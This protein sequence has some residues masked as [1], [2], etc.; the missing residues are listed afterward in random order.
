MFLTDHSYSVIAKLE[1]PTITKKSTKE[2]NKVIVNIPKPLLER[3]DMICE[4]KYYTRVE[5]IK[6]ALHEFIINNMPEDRLL[7][8]VQK[9]VEEQTRST[10]HKL[11]QEF[12][13]V[14]VPKQKTLQQQKPALPIVVPSNRYNDT[15]KIDN[16]FRYHE[17]I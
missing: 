17:Y 9:I 4:A 12:A 8:S 1:N 7:S 14:N 5:G 13:V 3:F 16:R 10:F 15:K 2:H 6:Q 11:V